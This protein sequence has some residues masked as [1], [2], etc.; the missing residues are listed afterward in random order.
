[1]SMLK[2]KLQDVW[3]KF[4]RF[5][6]IHFEA[7]EQY[8]VRADNMA[9]LEKTQH[10]RKWVECDGFY[11]SVEYQFWTAIYKITVWKYPGWVHA[12]MDHPEQ[13]D[14]MLRPMKDKWLHEHG[15]KYLKDKS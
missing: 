10:E 3:Y 12:F 15:D 8:I 1:M 11:V 4:L 2:Y 14:G 5:T 7:P 9:L 6:G 13:I